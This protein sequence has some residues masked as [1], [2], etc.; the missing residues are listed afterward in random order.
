M[1]NKFRERKFFEGKFLREKFLKLLWIIIL[2]RNF[3][4]VISAFRRMS[5]RHPAMVHAGVVGSTAVSQYVPLGVCK[6]CVSTSR[7][8]RDSYRHAE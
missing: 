4:F 5:N 2:A 6:E 8:Q 3:E 1:D 7:L